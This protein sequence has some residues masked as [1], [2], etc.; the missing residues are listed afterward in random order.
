MACPGRGG[1][2]RATVWSGVVNGAGRCLLGRRQEFDVDQAQTL[3]E[4]ESRGA[5]AGG[6]ATRNPV[7]GVHHAESTC[8][9]RPRRIPIHQK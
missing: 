1:R 5:P 7:N 3:A 4:R 8:Q 2:A 9:N 6:V